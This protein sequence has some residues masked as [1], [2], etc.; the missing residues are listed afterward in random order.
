MGSFVAIDSSQ[1]EVGDPVTKELWDKTKCNFDDLD[2][3]TT[4]LETLGSKII[5][6]N[7]SWAG[8]I[9]VS[10]GALT[11]L[12]SFE[13]AQDMR[14]ITAKIRQFCA[15]SSGVTE[16][17]IRKGTSE[18]GATTIF[19]VR[20]RL[21]SGDGDNAQDGGTIISPNVLQGELIILDFTQIQINT[22]KV[23]VTIIG[24]PL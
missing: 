9:Q 2:S 11:H 6:D 20:P 8:L 13:A 19:S 16:I 18:P 15:G 23:Q 1:I 24:E 21:L 7:T 14:I 3:R 22:G 17:D 5:V 4:A 12:A 10:G